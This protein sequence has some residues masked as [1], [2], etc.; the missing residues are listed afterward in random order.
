[1]GYFLL[2]A[3]RFRGRL[4][5]PQYTGMSPNGAMGPK[6]LNWHEAVRVTFILLSVC[7]TTFSCCYWYCS[8][9]LAL[10]QT[11]CVFLVLSGNFALQLHTNY[12]KSVV[13]SS[14][15]ISNL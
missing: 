3:N 4:A 8:I 12:A 15:S 2:C 6:E 11:V 13:E 7:Y 9:R 10:V 5:A 1:M 14:G